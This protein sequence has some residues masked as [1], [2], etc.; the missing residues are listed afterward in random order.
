MF[1][2]Q[3]TTSLSSMPLTKSNPVF[4]S[5]VMDRSLLIEQYELAR[6]QPDGLDSF[7]ERVAFMTL[8]SSE[9]HCSVAAEHYGIPVFSQIRSNLAFE[10][11]CGCELILC[12]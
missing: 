1:E 9:S 2:D 10:C 6:Q 5:N 3:L 4:K 12:V 11:V 7:R 8:S